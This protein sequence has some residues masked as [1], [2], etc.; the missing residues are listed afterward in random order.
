MELN[1]DDFGDRPY[2]NSMI[3]VWGLTYW[4]ALLV[5]P[6]L[7]ANFDPLVS[8]VSLAL[9]GGIVLGNL[10]VDSDILWML[11]G[12]FMASGIVSSWVG[13]TR[14]A[15]AHSPEIA[16][17]SMAAGNLVAALAFFAKAFAS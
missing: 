1:V 15:V 14:W 7:V 16:A 9:M 10:V 8:A 6:G 2:L 4:S 11:L 12:A 3:V 17:I 13:T 5:R